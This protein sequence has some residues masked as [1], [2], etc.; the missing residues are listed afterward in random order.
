M[1][2]NNADKEV[3]YEEMLNLSD[4]STDSTPRLGPDCFVLHTTRW[5][6]PVGAILLLP[7]NFQRGK[8]L[9]QH[10]RTL[11]SGDVNHAVGNM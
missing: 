6:G 4:I 11:P 9:T 3:V 5:L 1:K 7:Q 10:S 2:S 8:S